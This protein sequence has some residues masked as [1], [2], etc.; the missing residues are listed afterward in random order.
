MTRKQS[1]IDGRIALAV[2][3]IEEAERTLKILVETMEA[4]RR[5]QAEIARVNEEG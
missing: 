5:M 4:L 3:L 2:Q 1:E